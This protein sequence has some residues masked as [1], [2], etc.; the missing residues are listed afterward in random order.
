MAVCNISTDYN[1]TVSLRPRHS[2]S[3]IFGYKSFD[4]C[5]PAGNHR[6]VT[7]W[8]Y[9]IWN[10]LSAE[11]APVLQSFRSHEKHN[12]QTLKTYKIFKN[13]RNQTRCRLP[14]SFPS[15]WPELIIAC[16][17][18][19][20]GEWRHRCSW[21]LLQ[22]ACAAYRLTYSKHSDYRQTDRRTDITTGSHIASFAFIGGGRKKN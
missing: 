8:R 3:F 17:V 6:Q 4:A 2:S 12:T 18:K 1:I 11:F 20:R 14:E 10:V 22:L 7:T 5:G 19:G 16:D 21:R 15:A 9:S 13:I